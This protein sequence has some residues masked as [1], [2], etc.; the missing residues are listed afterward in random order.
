LGL[1]RLLGNLLYKV[2]PRDPLSFGLALLV[3]AVAALSA[4]FLPAWRATRTDP[5][6]ALRG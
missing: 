2:S 1:T 3:M 5:V 4:T 6:C